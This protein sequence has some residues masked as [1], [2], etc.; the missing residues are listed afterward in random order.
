VNELPPPSTLVR[1]GVF[2]L[3]TETGELL[4]QGSRVRL[5]EQ[6]FQVLRILLERRGRVVTREELQR[7]IWPADTF[8][9]FDRGLYNAI[10]KL[11]EALGDDA[12][13]PGFVETLSKRGYRFIGPIQDG[14]RAISPEQAQSSPTNVKTTAPETRRRK[15]VSVL[16][17]GAAAVASMVLVLG[18]NPRGMRYR[19]FGKTGAPLIQ[20]LAV[21]PLQNLSGD[22]NQEYF[23]DG[24]TDALITN[25]AQIGSLK[26]ISR[27]SSMQYKQ[28]KKALPEVA[29]ELK[30]DAIIEGTVQRSGGRVRIT[31]QLIDAAGDKH[32]W[33]NSYERDVTN[34][35]SL[36]REV[37]DDIASQVRARIGATGQSVSV[38]P[39]PVSVDALESYLQG[40]FHLNKSEMGPRDEE[41]RKA[42]AFFEKALNADPNFVPAYIGLSEAHHN[43][44]W[45]ASEDFE[46]MKTAAEK[47]LAL[48]P[49]S[50]EAHRAVAMTKFE[51][52]DWTG[53]E[54]ECRRA[55]ALNANNAAAH[56]LLGDSLGV[57][58]QMDEGWSE[59]EIAQELDPN[60]DHLS[61]ALSRRGEHDR[62]IELLLKLADNHPE[63]GLV[64]WELAQN[65]AQKG[66]Y[67][68]WDRELAKSMRLFGFPELADQLHQSFVKSGYTG[69]LRHWARE[70]ERLAATKQVYM[71]GV[72]AEAYAALSDNDRAFYWLGQGCQHRHMAISDPVLVWVKIDPGFASLRSDARFRDL[73]HCM[74]IPP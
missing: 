34:I 71:P 22:P 65:Y 27:T 41:L 37:T 20:S 58:G 70:G 55:I 59:Y 40:N 51:D 68:E 43:L 56:Y 54:E 30:V 18:L 12:E 49:N 19:L 26:V 6:P 31:A 29:R 45:P 50:S 61:W 74:G 60:Q 16:F 17:W 10:K 69:A 48:A 62:A 2:E 67:K 14:T 11:R 25:L 39:R 24:M 33:A 15:S 64:H 13:R 42:G 72:L 63:D 38:Q 9:D 35:F 44:W 23:S 53:A 36:Q 66:M 1:F 5:Q 52:W 73:L 21:L 8:V 7:R 57:R 46:V 47:A 4:K 32:L 3:D 28:T